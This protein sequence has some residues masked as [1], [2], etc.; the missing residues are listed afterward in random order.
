[1]IVERVY[2]AE[3][4]EQNAVNAAE[5][6]KCNQKL[7]AEI[8]ADCIHAESKAIIRKSRRVDFKRVNDAISKRWPKGL[9]RI[10]QMAWKI[11][12][13]KE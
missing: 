1:M 6:R 9:L 5:D 11:V 12:E 4:E 8:Y 3:I 7:M 13:G 2:I 10:K